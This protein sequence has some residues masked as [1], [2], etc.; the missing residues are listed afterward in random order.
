MA[1]KMGK[2]EL[3]TKMIWGFIIVLFP[4]IA[5]GINLISF[6]HLSSSAQDYSI[7]ENYYEEIKSSELISDG[8]Q[9]LK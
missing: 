7:D 4:I 5:V 6:F 2:A 3:K 1:N 8:D 9:V